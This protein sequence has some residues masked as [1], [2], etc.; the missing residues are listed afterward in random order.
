MARFALIDCGVFTLH[1]NLGPAFSLA[2]LLFLFFGFFAYF[3][4]GFGTRSMFAFATGPTLIDAFAHFLQR[5]FS[6]RCRTA[7]L[8]FHL[9]QFRVILI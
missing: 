2:L 7:H 5:M 3:I 9:C 6:L 4:F 8:C 1:Q